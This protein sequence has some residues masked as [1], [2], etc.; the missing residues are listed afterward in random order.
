MGMKLWGY[1]KPRDNAAVDL[2]E[3]TLVA[4]PAQLRKIAAFLVQAAEGIEKHGKGWEHE[5]LADQ[6][7]GFRSSPQF[8]VFNSQHFKK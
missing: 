3:V 4:S 8:I 6:V 7:P 1:P 2:S 5:H